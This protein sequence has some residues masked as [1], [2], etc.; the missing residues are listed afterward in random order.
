VLRSVALVL[1]DRARAEEVTQ[2]AFVRAL[3]RWRSVRTMARPAAWV[4]VVAVNVER[5][6]WKREVAP[7]ESSGESRFVEDYSA[8]VATGVVLREAL[9][10]LTGRQRAAVV[11]R[12]FSDL[13]VADIARALGCAE[14]TVKATLHTALTK[15]RVDLAGGE[16]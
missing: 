3:L 10:R 12:Y 2:E 6:R 14:G 13:S 7:A 9:G 8:T 15:L 16:P 11:L 5:R 4:L 1:G